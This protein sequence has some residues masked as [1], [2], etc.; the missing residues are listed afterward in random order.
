MALWSEVRNQL[1]ISVKDEY[2]IQNEKD[3]IRTMIKI[4]EERELAQT[5]PTESC[6]IK[7]PLTQREK[8]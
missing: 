1:N 3:S 5:Q 4:R 6:N 8:I 7:Q 2:I